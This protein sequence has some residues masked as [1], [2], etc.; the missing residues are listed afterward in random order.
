MTNR[1][2][3]ALLLGLL[4]LAAMASG[5]GDLQS[6]GASVKNKASLQRGAATYMSYCAGCHAIGYQRFS[7]MAADLDLTD[8]QVQTYLNPAG[9]KVGEQMHIAMDPADA[10]AWFGKTP[11]DLSLIARSKPGG[12]DWA[13]TFLKSFYVDESRP[14]G[15]NNTL[16]PNASM[17]NVLWELQGIQRPVYE[18]GEHGA[19]HGPSRLELASPGRLSPAEYDETVRDLVSFLTYV[20]EPAAMQRTSVGVWVILFLAAFTFLAWLLKHEYWRDVH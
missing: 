7:R 2:F 4:P 9:Q 6:S 20:G 14:S 5:G 12:P 19:S 17:P 11:P 18:G 8:E 10:Q 15:W 3:A 1:R 16:L 13:Y